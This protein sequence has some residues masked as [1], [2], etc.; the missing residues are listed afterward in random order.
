MNTTQHRPRGSGGTTLAV[1]LAVVLAHTF[2]L[3]PAPTS[4]MARQAPDAYARTATAGAEADAVRLIGFSDLMVVLSQLETGG[5]SLAGDF[6]NDGVVDMRDVIEVVRN[7]GEPAPRP[8][9][10]ISPAALAPDHEG[11]D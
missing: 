7:L 2:A 11:P 8:R 10:D 9:I 6:N 5:P 3:A 1:L 4:A